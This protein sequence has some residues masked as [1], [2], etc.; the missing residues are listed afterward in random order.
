MRTIAFVILAMGSLPVFASSEE[1][2]SRAS[3]GLWRL[4]WPDGRVGYL[5]VDAD[6]QPWRS[7]GDENRIW[8][9]SVEDVSW[10]ER[11]GNAMRHVKKKT[12]RHWRENNAYRL[13]LTCDVSHFNGARDG[14]EP[15]SGMTVINRT[16]SG[17]LKTKLRFEE[18]GVVRSP[19]RSDGAVAVP[20]GMLTGSHTMTWLAT[21]PRSLPAGSKCRVPTPE[22]PE[23]SEW[24][25]CNPSLT[26][27]SNP[28]GRR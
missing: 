25:A 21:C 16:W 17:D 4:D 20:E 22:Y 13:E 10:R 8:A 14:A 18:R 3:D 15:T 28:S 6:F 27:E 7:V 5:C 9:C 26:G 2:T 23:S 12:E 11:S 24:P 1:A 19:E